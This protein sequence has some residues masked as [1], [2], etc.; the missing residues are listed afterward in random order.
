MEQTNFVLSNGVKGTYLQ[1]EDLRSLSVAVVVR[2]GSAYEDGANSGI[3]HLLE[4]L[5]FNKNSA[6][7]KRELSSAFASIGA[8][9]NASTSHELLQY[10]LWAPQERATEALRLLSLS[11]WDSDFDEEDLTKEKTIIA[12]EI[13]QTSDDPVTFF[14][15]SMLAN[16]YMGHGFGRPV[17]GTLESLRGLTVGDLKAWRDENLVPKN[18]TIAICGSSKWDA[19]LEAL[20]ERNFGA[21][22]NPSSKANL[23]PAPQF[24]P[25]NISL[26]KGFG[27]SYLGRIYSG[28]PLFSEDSPA[29]TVLSMILGHGETSRIWLKLREEM[30]VAYHAGALH[31]SSPVQ[32]LF[33]MYAIADPSQSKASI[34]AM[35][36]ELQAVASEGP[37]PEEMDRNRM[38][39]LSAGIQTL[40]SASLWTSTS[41][42]LLAIYGFEKGIK[43]HIDAMHTVSAGDVVRVAK[44]LCRS[45]ALTLE[46]R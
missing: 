39:L 43:E 32:G 36:G 16:A 5:T 31:F 20:V 9:R 24:C 17:G 2:I 19:A 46:I 45:D 22:N 25:G 10:T 13:R 30:G 42:I 6:M 18:M 28:S 7:S 8:T 3:T 12:N 14:N 4:H 1:R 27:Q 11:I 33:S 23:L 44:H 37:S 40:E 15:E 29:T 21:K 34:E 26:S 38:T 41:A 35:D